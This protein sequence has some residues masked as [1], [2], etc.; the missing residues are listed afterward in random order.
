MRRLIGT[1]DHE[2]SEPL[3]LKRGLNGNK[4]RG[5]AAESEALREGK[6]DALQ[7]EGNEKRD[8]EHRGTRQGIMQEEDTEPAR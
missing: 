7:G 8:A 3:T 6:T 4:E 2:A 5:N 1:M